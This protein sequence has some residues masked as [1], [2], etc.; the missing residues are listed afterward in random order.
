M[1][2][3]RKLRKSPS[4]SLA[5][6]TA[7]LLISA[8][9]LSSATESVSQFQD[10]GNVQVTASAGEV[11]PPANFTVRNTTVG[12]TDL[13]WTPVAD[14]FITGY[15]ILRSQ[16][17]YGPWAEI[18]HLK[19]RTISTYTDRT[20]GSTM[21]FYRAESV[22][23]SNWASTSPGYEAP[24]PVGRSFYDSFTVPGN[25]DGRRTEDGSSVWQVW[26]GQISIDYR[27][28]WTY[29]AHAS[30]YETKPAVG[31]VRT[32]TQ[33]AMV[34][35][36]DFDGSEAFVFRGKDPLNYIY[37]GGAMGGHASDG[38]FEIVEYRNGVRNVLFSGNT[39]AI[40][41]DFRLEVQGTEIRLYIDAKQNDNKSGT[42]F[43]KVSSNYLYGDPTATYFG[44]GFTDWFGFLGYQFEAY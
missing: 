12:Q 27:S 37:A 10:N 21:W 39:G 44:I 1:K 7:V 11:T 15:K 5:A 41:R 38:S 26:S 42:L 33:D 16:S 43:A 3:R 20:S 31:V 28:G 14:D 13:S 17:K 18:A 32:P 2:A 36:K 6:I 24:P 29:A 23:P 9:S 35:G 40:D 22:G 30:G 4:G 8:F 34:F 25:L 19:S